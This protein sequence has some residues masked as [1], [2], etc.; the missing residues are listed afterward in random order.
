MKFL[1]GGKWRPWNG[2]ST[3]QM[4]ANVA[5]IAT[6]GTNAVWVAAPRP[7]VD[8]LPAPDPLAT[9]KARLHEAESALSLVRKQLEA[10]REDREVM[11]GQSRR[12]ATLFLERRA[13][14]EALR[15]VNE[16][17]RTA[18][19]NAYAALR[20]AVGGIRALKTKGGAKLAKRLEKALGE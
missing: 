13:E 10:V 19:T 9:L 15:T 18:L 14:L 12:F 17:T 16:E 11:Q 1:Q 4:E 5:S 6:D 2:G 3:S 7:T 20:L 8:P